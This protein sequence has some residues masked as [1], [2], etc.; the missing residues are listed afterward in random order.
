MNSLSAVGPAGDGAGGG[1]AAHGLGKP[2]HLLLQRVAV[3]LQVLHAEPA[4]FQ[5]GDASL[6]LTGLFMYRDEPAGEASA[7]AFLGD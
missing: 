3:E 5:T 4:A 2:G 1:A 7:R 6:E